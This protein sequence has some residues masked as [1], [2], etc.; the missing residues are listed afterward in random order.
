MW[1]EDTCVYDFEGSRYVLHGDGECQDGE[2]GSVD[3]VCP[4]G[5][6]CADCGP[7]VMWPPSPPPAPPFAPVPTGGEV[8]NVKSFVFTFDMT[9]AIDVVLFD[10]QRKLQLKESIKELC[11]CIKPTCYVEIR[12]TGGSV[13]VSAM[14]IVPM[15]DDLTATRAAGAAV[16][17]AATTLVTQDTTSLST[18]LGVPVAQITPTVSSQEGVTVPIA[19][20]PPAPTPPPPLAPPPQTPSLSAIA[21]ALVTSADGG[22]SVIPAAAGG[23]VVVLILAAVC[24]CRSR[25]AT[26][27]RAARQGKSVGEALPDGHSLP[28]PSDSVVSTKTSHPL[29]P[30]PD[31]G[32]STT[33]S[34]DLPPPRPNPFAKQPVARE[35]PAVSTDAAHGV[36]EYEDSFLPISHP[37]AFERTSTV[38]STISATTF[39]ESF[40]T[41]LQSPTISARDR[42]VA[43]G[44]P[45]AGALAV[46]P[47]WT[48]PEANKYS[49]KLRTIHGH[50]GS[51]KDIPARLVPASGRG[52]ARPSGRAQIGVQETTTKAPVPQEST[53]VDQVKISVPETTTAADEA[54]SSTLATVP[55]ATAAAQSKVDEIKYT[56]RVTLKMR[57]EAD[58]TSAPAGEMPANT[59]VYVREW[60]T[61]P[62]GTRRAHVC[63]VGSSPEKS[64]WL[65][66]V[67]KDGRDTLLITTGKRMDNEVEA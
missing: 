61:L 33:T 49:D 14:L 38:G 60:H 30:P 62:N 43:A 40:R 23:V 53:T 5:T 26:K 36:D 27:R 8:V 11:V 50:V 66:C 7:R 22:S 24:M 51:M 52:S 44:L 15:G 16:E 56:V 6:D 3:D 65:S 37:S 39:M 2:V 32:V 34:H 1:C 42:T 10:L 17:A 13:G 48:N 29:P 9:L 35:P 54:K 47:L 46:P 28:P 31:G 25:A 18:S 4:L 59:C 55:E 41:I 20:A 21:S 57:A 64:G 67:A 45:P 19:L 58:M 12:I 63:E